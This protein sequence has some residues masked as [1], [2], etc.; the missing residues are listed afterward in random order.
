MADLKTSAKMA[1]IGDQRVQRKSITRIQ[2]APNTHPRVCGLAESMFPAARRSPM[3]KI[4]IFQVNPP[5]NDVLRLV[6]IDYDTKTIN[7]QV[8]N[9]E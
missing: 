9:I 1:S 2:N 5:P 8:N 6:H 7:R 3:T 4:Q